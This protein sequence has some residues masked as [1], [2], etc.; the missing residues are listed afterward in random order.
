MTK[1]NN[2]INNKENVL[3]KSIFTSK[4]SEYS[5]DPS[6]LNLATPIYEHLEHKLFYPWHTALS[7]IVASQLYIVKKY[8]NNIHINIIKKVIIYFTS[9]QVSQV[10]L[11]STVF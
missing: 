7:L 6:F 3:K 1:N 11:F 10:L 5:S 4:H 2:I 8:N 9:A